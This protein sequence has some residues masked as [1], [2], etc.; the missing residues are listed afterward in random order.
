MD[1]Q[2]IYIK[3]LRHLSETKDNYNYVGRSAVVVWK[4]LDSVN[5][6]GKREFRR[7]CKEN[8][9]FL[10]RKPPARQHILDFLSFCFF[11]E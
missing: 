7:F 9:E 1:K 3:Y 10:V 6:I 5:S 2:Q 8:A 11:L 4:F